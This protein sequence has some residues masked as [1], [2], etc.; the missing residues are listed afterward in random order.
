[1]SNFI[2]IWQTQE[3]TK[4]SYHNSHAFLKKIDALPTQGAGWTCDVV[5]SKEN[6]L[7]EDGKPLPA[8]KLEL[9]RQDPVECVRELLGNPT[10][11]DHIKYAPEQVYED[12]EMK[13]RVFDEMWTVDWWWDTQV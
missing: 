2:D 9:W 6:Q 13:S 4:P 7:N 8:E 12:D 10:L 5:T 3:W 1:M 11:K